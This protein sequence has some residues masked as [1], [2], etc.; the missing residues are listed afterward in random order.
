MR[1]RTS[2]GSSGAFFAGIEKFGVRWKTVRWAACSAISGIDWIPDEPVP[3]TPTRWPVKST[4]SCGQRP[5]WYVGP[6]NVPSP[7]TSGSLAADRQPTA[8]TTNRAETVS[9]RSV[10]VMPRSVVTDQRSVDSSNTA[11]VTLVS[12]SMSWRRSKRSA[13]WL[14]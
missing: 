10:D 13:T 5:V 1:W 4:P 8:S 14:A 9:S 11:L 12:N 2:S 3:I 7:G 6:A